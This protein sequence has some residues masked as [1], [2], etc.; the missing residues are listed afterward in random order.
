MQVEGTSVSSKDKVYTSNGTRYIGST[1]PKNT[2]GS[3]SGG[4]TSSHRSSGGSS[5]G[6]SSAAAPVTTASGASTATAS[7]TNSAYDA[8]QKYLA[9]MQAA[10][11]AELAA[12]QQRA[13]DAYNANMGALNDSYNT[14]RGALSDNYNSS[15]GQLG[16][17]RDYSQQSI[18]DDAAKSLKEAYINKM[19]SQRNM[20]QNLA[21]Q[22]LGGGMSETSQ[23]SLLNN[24]GSSRNNIN[25]TA[26]KSLSDLQQEYN[27]NVAKAQQQYNSALSDLAAQKAQ[28][29]ME[30]RNNLE[31]MI[32]SGY[33]SYD[34]LKS[35]NSQMAAQM[36]SLLANQN[37][38]T[39]D[40]TQATNTFVATNSQQATPDTSSTNWEE[41]LKSLQNGTGT[42][43]VTTASQG[44]ATGNTN[45][46]ANILN[47]LAASY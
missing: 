32:E 12:K 43:G 24:Y 1:A 39:Y 3:G 45:Y 26:A 10:A 13:Q 6:S 4:S 30:L 46:L 18:N 31:N 41:Y 11:E 38:Y 29:E 42:S 15:L 9:E 21:A 16:S 27:T 36:A 5:S 34:N 25:T 17:A 14:Q 8:Y 28:Y 19:L 44:N 37:A 2:S 40:P 22:G 47:Q 33:T 20:A 7:S 23:A 35:N